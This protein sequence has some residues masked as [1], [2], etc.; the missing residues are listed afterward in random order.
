MFISTNVKKNKLAIKRAP[1]KKKLFESEF[2]K[3]V[4]EL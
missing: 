1:I 2:E 3:A 4:L